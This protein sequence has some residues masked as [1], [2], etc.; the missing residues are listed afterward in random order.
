MHSKADKLPGIVLFM[1]FMLAFSLS[2]AWAENTEVVVFADDSFPPYSYGEGCE[3]EGIYTEI[4]R[5]A[6]SRMNGY[7]VTIKALPW[8][9]GLYKLE[10]GVGFALYPPYYLPD[11][12]PYMD[13]SVPIYRE[14]IIV[15][16]TENLMARLPVKPQWPKDFYGLRAGMNLGFAIGGNEFRDAVNKGSITLIETKGNEENLRGLINGYIDF[17]VND[18]TAIMAGI[19]ALK[20]K[21][22]YDGGVSQARLVEGLTVS[23]EYAY[24]G[25]TNTDNGLFPFKKNFME[26]F[27]AIIEDMHKKK[28]ISRI[29]TEYLEKEHVSF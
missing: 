2:P 5:K 23:S 8:K 6:F 19:N 14:E 12:R 26:Q 28:E 7:A 3:V 29:V 17:Y 18:R 13:Y 11:E 24:L 1:T 16:T 27:N 25:Y 20:R 15:F 4:L 22:L 21:G 10:K 9:R